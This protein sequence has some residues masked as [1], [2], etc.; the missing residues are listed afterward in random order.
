[1]PDRMAPKSAQSVGQN[2]LQPCLRKEGSK[3]VIFRSGQNRG[4]SALI[5]TNLVPKF[6]ATD[7]LQTFLRPLS[8]KPTEKK[9]VLE[10]VLF[11][12]PPK[13][14]FSRIKRVRMTRAI[15]KN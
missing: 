10:K 3:T 13:T 14:R 11:S 6:R 7:A 8:T 4:Q 9:V 1:M 15:Q 12:R 5:L 2:M